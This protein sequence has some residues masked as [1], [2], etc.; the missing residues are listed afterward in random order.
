MANG[1]F[2]PI[3]Q[4]RDWDGDF[5]VYDGTNVILRSLYLKDPTGIVFIESNA[6]LFF[7]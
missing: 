2:N 1:T 6:E 5:I 7:I 4:I 3:Y